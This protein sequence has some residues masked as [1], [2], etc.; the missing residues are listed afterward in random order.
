[1]RQLIL[2][3]GIFH[4]FHE[5]SA[6]LMQIAETLGI[7][8]EVVNHPEVAFEQLLSGTIDVFTVN[9]LHWP[10]QGEKY[11]PF[12]SEWRYQMSDLGE[13]AL[14]AFEKS[15]GRLLGVHTAS[16]CFTDSSCWSRLMG[17]A[18]HWGQSFHPEPQALEVLPTL[19]GR[20]MNLSDFRVVDELYSA[21]SIHQDTEVLMVGSD[22]LSTQPLVWRRQDGEFRSAYCALG[23]DTRAMKT[24]GLRLVLRRLLMWLLEGG[25]D[26]NH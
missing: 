15:G 19:T 12:R 25:R 6:E 7:A 24:E 17:G 8:S 5:T 9:G 26:E 14:T 1:V 2:S 13:S 18:W 23:H 11:D 22:G 21:L 3:S 10:M 4:E 16:I 20:E